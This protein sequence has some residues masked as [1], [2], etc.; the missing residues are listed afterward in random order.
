[1][2]QDPF[3]YATVYKLMGKL[4]ETGSLHDKPRSCRPCLSEEG[5]SEGKTS[6]HVRRFSSFEYQ[7][8]NQRY[9]GFSIVKSCRVVHKILLKIC[10]IGRRVLSIVVD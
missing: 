7:S 4:F 9:E 6:V 10:I 3:S 1:M 8:K 2:I 5:H